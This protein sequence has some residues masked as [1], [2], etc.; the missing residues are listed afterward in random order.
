MSFN[1]SEVSDRIADLNDKIKEIE[2]AAAT[3]TKDLKAEVK[4]LED[5]LQ[6]AM[7][8]AGVTTVKG[9][10]SEASIKESL[11]VGFQDFEAFAQF[12]KRKNALHLFERRIAVTAY[13]E[14][15]ESL[16]NKPIPG[17]SEFLQTKVTVKRVKR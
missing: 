1:F 5:R 16:G 11:R 2:T 14:M 3:K 15:K 17:L 7:A 8:D 6:L 13:R 10:S 9:A 4:D 12:A